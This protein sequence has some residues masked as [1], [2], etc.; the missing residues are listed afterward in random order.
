MLLCFFPT[1]T[2]A[3]KTPLS[4]SPHVLVSLS[5]SQLPSRH[6]EDGAT[7]VE[8]FRFW[9]QPFVHT[10]G[11][12]LFLR[13]VTFHY[14]GDARGQILRYRL[15]LA[16][17]QIGFLSLPDS[18][19]FTFTNLNL[20]LPSSKTIE[21]TLVGDVAYGA[22]Y[23]E[24]KFS[25][26]SATDV[27]VE[28][29]NDEGLALKIFGSF[30]LQGNHIELGEEPEAPSEECNM[31]EEPVCAEDGRTYFNPCIPFQKG[32][33]IVS[34]AACEEETPDQDVFSACTGDFRPVC[35]GDGKTYSNECFLTRSE[36][37][38]AYEG[39]CFPS[40][41]PEIKTVATAATL[42]EIKYNQLSTLRPRLP[43]E[44]Y[45]Q[46]LAI[47]AVLKTFT[48]RAEPK[49]QV[50]EEID[51]FLRFSQNN[52]DRAAL[53]SAIE[54]LKAFVS[55]QQAETLQ[56]KFDQGEIPFLDV[57]DTAWYMKPIAFFKSQGWASGYL[58]PEGQATG[59]FRPDKPVSY[60]EAT[61][62]AFAAAGIVPSGEATTEN[63]YAFG[64]WAGSIIAEAESRGLTAWT[65][66]P[67]PDKRISRG[68]MVQLVL[69]VFGQTIPEAL[70][71][72]FPDMSEDDPYFDAIEYARSKGIVQ[73]YGD[74]TFRSD[75]LLS[76]AEA[77][78]IIQFAYD[79]LT[80]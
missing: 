50:L 61:K 70:R 6:V 65:S 23:A 28:E 15:L 1:V 55:V 36:Q 73:G 26:I 11:D 31:R 62:W 25:I 63:T 35:G 2:W 47:V 34:Y 27:V 41:F 12:S 13:S 56:Q 67:N 10:E 60:A 9:L 72:P 74:F 75:N 51:A 20:E 30:P 40:E 45:E 53:A 24:H 66:L 17:K 48:F 44:S 14:D 78:K 64:H 71:S 77:A 4:A 57:N 42:L 21:L 69:E 58:D 79:I 33:R 38:L 16:E 54:E 43:E 52:S 22:D 68:E 37:S 32:L 5:S 3:V 8:L 59:L 7:N 49:F 76:R 29:D 19:T 39:A 18:D 80:L 46:L